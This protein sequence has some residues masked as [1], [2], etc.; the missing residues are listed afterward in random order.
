MNNLLNNEN[1]NHVGGM[2][3]VSDDWHACLSDPLSE[4]WQ[5]GEYRGLFSRLVAF[6]DAV[7]NT[8]TVPFSI[9]RMGK[10]KGA[11]WT[12]D[13][14]SLA[15][16]FTRFPSLSDVYESEWVY[17]PDLQLFFD[18]FRR[19]PEFGENWP[20]CFP[21][22]TLANERIAAEAYNEFIAEL[23]YEARH[24]K[25]KRKLKAWKG[26]LSVQ[27]R[28]IRKKLYLATEGRKRLIPL[29]LDWQFVETAA[30]REDALP[31][32]SWQVDW[33]GKWARVPVR[34]GHG[35]PEARPRIDTGLAMR[36]RELFFD[37]Q[38]GADAAFFEHL[39]MYGSKMENG[40]RHRANHF[41]ILF[42]FDA[43]KIKVSDLDR[44][45]NLAADRWRRVTGGLGLTFD[46]RDRGDVDFLRR[47]GRW[48]LDP[49]DCA[50]T[51][52]FEA[53]VRYFVE[54]CTDD[55]DQ[56]VRVKPTKGA[57]TLTMGRGKPSMLASDVQGNKCASQPRWESS[58]SR[59]CKSGVP[60]HFPIEASLVS[61]LKSDGVA[62]KEEPGISILSLP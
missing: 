38:R 52:Q 48:V 31:R 42:L 54:Y 29:R 4:C 8:D 35:V 33:E 22:W 39:V 45:R 61:S 13:S 14:G 47:T 51:Q 53:L 12:R 20:S 46:S 24:R 27:A 60:Y 56:M 57:R 16:Y 28:S 5:L 17:S 37:N 3:S 55:K 19:H 18:C 58:A 6:M 30:V 36:Y 10:R 11:V 40:G 26:G 25:V 34:S 15:S 50:D 23:R 44:L 7:L 41:H 1:A 21:K 2:E 62:K 59:L 9:E 32:L 43:E 49:I